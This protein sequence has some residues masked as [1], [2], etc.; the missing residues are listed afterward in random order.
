M[1]VTL[2]TGVSLQGATPFTEKA[3]NKGNTNLPNFRFAQ[4]ANPNQDPPFLA[5][6][7]VTHSSRVPG[8]NFATSH[9]R[10]R[11]QGH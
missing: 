4:V 11:T 8:H 6:L 3:P 2:S 5:G 7:Q 9:H 10:V 1:M